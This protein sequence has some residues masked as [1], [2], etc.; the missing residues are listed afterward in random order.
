MKVKPNLQSQLVTISETICRQT[1][2]YMM[3]PV[4]KVFGVA[5]LIAFFT[6]PYILA[7]NYWDR[8]EGLF[9]SQYWFL[10]ITS[11]GLGFIVHVGTLIIYLIIYKMNHPFLEQFKDTDRPWPW[12]YDP[13]F[14]SKIIKAIK[15]VSLNN[16]VCAPMFVLINCSTGMLRGRTK[17]EEIPS[18]PVYM[19][20]IVFMMFC[21]D[22]AFYHGH[23]LL[24]HPKLYPYIHKIHHE[25]YDTICLSSEYAHPVEYLL[26]NM[27]PTGMGYILFAGRAHHLSFL[28]FVTLR[29][30]ETVESHG[31]Y[32]F[33]WAMTRILPLC[34]SSKYHNYHHLKNIGNYGS[35][36]ILWD[37]IWGTNSHYYKEL[38][39]SDKTFKNYGNV[40]SLEAQDKKTK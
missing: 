26:A 27:M 18:F 14:R 25:W 12:N 8:F 31:G 1:H 36:F 3:H 37:S 21:E 4:F 11:V 5:T 9:P 24:H 13:E 7:V 29:L 16:F 6:V 33:P 20:Q 2:I 34:A 32:E 28:V 30:I 22:F 39:E 38:L 10:S 35:F 23:R 15:L 17:M 40:D 19:S